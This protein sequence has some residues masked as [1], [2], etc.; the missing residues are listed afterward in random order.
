MLPGLRLRH[1][2]ERLGLTYRNVESASYDLAL[3]RGRPEFILRI[4]RLADI[5]NRN[6]VPGL[7][8][9]YT[10]SVLYHLSPLELL[11]WFDVPLEECFEDGV[12]F[13]VPRTHMAAP[14]S[15]LRVPV[16]FDPG[17]DPRRTDFLSRMVERWGHFEGALIRENPRHCYAYVGLSDRRMVPLLRPGSLVLVDTEIQQIEEEGWASEHDRPMYLVDVREGYRCGWFQ[18]IPGKLIM[19]PHPLSRCVPES[20]RTPEDAEVVGKVIGIVTRLNEPWSTGPP[21]FRG[22]RVNSKRRVL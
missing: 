9:L 10:L 13:P 7:H 1:V 5:E 12:H 11:S 14:P 16:R 2:R 6:V 22:E 3:R 17:F 15:G 21:E 4:S 18:Q 19:Q 20:W 8:K